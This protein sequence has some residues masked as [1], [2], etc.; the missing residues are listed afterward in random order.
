MP[1]GSKGLAGYAR[2]VLV[3]ER[4]QSERLSLNQPKKKGKQMS[5][6]ST[7]VEETKA[8][9]LEDKAINHLL[10]RLDE[11]IRWRPGSKGQYLD[12]HS[13]LE[14]IQGETNHVITGR[15]GSGKTRLL[16]ELRAVAEKKRFR[17]VSI[18]AE[19]YKE[20][21]YPDILIQILRAF[22][23]QFVQELTPRR[24]LF[25]PE[26]WGY[27]KSCVLHPIRERENSRSANEIRIR[28]DALLATLDKLLAESDEL[29]AEY[30]ESK[31][32]QAERTTNSSLKAAVGPAFV[33]AS[34]NAQSAEA[35]ASNRT[36]K[37]R[38]YKRIKVERLL[39]DFKRLLAHFCKHFNAKVVLA[40]DDFY[41]IRREDQPKVID[42]MHRICKDTKSFLKVATIRHR[43][44]LFEHA[45]IKPD[46]VSLD[47]NLG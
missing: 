25:S 32:D 40:V 17:V 37:Q 7:P 30:S 29:D 46:P 19:D 22:L 24:M 45:H 31:S 3:L 27:L 23:H 44:E 28:A 42:Y 9:S 41:F 33:E 35:T 34:K 36:A 15:R 18:G 12:L 47:T 10:A 16:D 5:S 14:R 39:V 13:A 20:L 21:T 26:W 1:I 8:P 2:K 6:S 38:E 43:T 4:D 11:L